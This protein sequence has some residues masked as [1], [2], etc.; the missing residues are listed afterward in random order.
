MKEFF[1]AY[2]SG[3]KQKKRERAWT[4]FF[5]N[6]SV[7]IILFI[8]GIFIGLLFRNNQLINHEIL[9]RARADISHILMTREWNAHYG[10]VY[11]EKR[12]GVESSPYLDDPDIE[13]VDGKVYTLKN[14]ALMTREISEL[15][16]KDG[17]LMFHMTSMKPLNP[18]NKPDDF[19]KNALGLFEKGKKEVYGK[20]KAGD[21]TSFRY[22]SPLFV[23][24]VCLKCHA[25]QGYKLG[26][27]R[28][29]ISVKFDI[30]RV[31][32]SIAFNNV[33][34]ILLGI[35]SAI[36]LLVIIYSFAVVLK[37]K[38]E[39]AQKKL[40]ELAIIDDLTGLYNR[41]YFFSRLS[42]ET[43][44]SKR[45]GQSLGC[46]IL[47]IDLFKEV[48]D[49]YGHLAGDVVLKGL[50]DTVKSCCR[51][52]DTVA[53]YGGEEIII[54]LPGTDLKGSYGLS[55]KIRKAVE[56]MKCLY[57]NIPISVTVSLGAVSFTAEDLGKIEKNYDVMV[58]YADNAL[59]RAKNNGRNRS[60][61]AE[62][63]VI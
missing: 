26:D 49:S 57:E 61:I 16:E 52:I 37:K 15:F 62:N 27:M 22:M 17:L 2:M 29:G 56:N 63:L 38:L 5:L 47:D 30:T 53:R 18:D 42:Y 35:V 60:E 14:P 36:T 28:G 41:R 21:R 50:A 23:D 40:K 9:T 12:E 4:H 58:K 43:H 59:Y 39:R 34:I 1:K 20:E 45:F 19:E 24:D 48:N 55:E 32:E 10:G 51:E 33:I 8:L 25:K 31:E 13:T 54:L 46:I 11:V 44:R 6:I 7:A 3:K